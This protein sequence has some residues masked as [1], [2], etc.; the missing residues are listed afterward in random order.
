MGL[1]TVPA[2]SNPVT[3]TTTAQYTVKTG[4][5]STTPGKYKLGDAATVNFTGSTSFQGTQNQ[6]FSNKGADSI[7][8]TWPGKLEANHINISFNISIPH[9]GTVSTNE[10]G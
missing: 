10:L 7:T 1:R 2:G 9:Q 4:D 5:G 6:K 3:L 8:L